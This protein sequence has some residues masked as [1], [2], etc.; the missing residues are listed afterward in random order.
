MTQLSVMHVYILGI[1]KSQEL[2]YAGMISNSVQYTNTQTLPTVC[3][4][5][6][7]V[8]VNV[9]LLLFTEKKKTKH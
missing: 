2:K 1:Y 4:L 9:R 8:S 6:E 3:H 5:S 7:I